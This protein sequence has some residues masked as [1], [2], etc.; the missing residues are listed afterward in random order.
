MWFT[1]PIWVPSVPRETPPP[2]FSFLTMEMP[3]SK[4]TPGLMQFCATG[5]PIPTGRLEFIRHAG[6]LLLF[7]EI[8][9]KGIQ[10]QMVS[11]AST[12]GGV[13]DRVQFN[14]SQI[15]IVYTAYDIKGKPVSR[16]SLLW[17]ISKNQGEFSEKPV[18]RATIT[19]NT[20][21]GTVLSWGA[22]AE[23]AYRVMA[24]RDAAGP[25]VEVQRYESA[26]TGLASITPPFNPDNQFFYLQEVPQSP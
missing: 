12:N 17:D 26:A 9:L 6:N 22:T 16:P 11:S 25:Y 13:G 8:T 23:R 21:G 20:E 3:V 4:A 10:V 24:A 2:R 18:F 19:F 5:Q 7:C 15:E 14:F 1:R